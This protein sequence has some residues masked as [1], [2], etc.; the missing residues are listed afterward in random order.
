MWKKKRSF[1]ETRLMI[2]GIRKID[3]LHIM[4]GI[5]DRKLTL[6]LDSNA[7]DFS[8]LP[9]DLEELFLGKNGLFLGK[10]GIVNVRRLASAQA[11]PVNAFRLVRNSLR[12]FNDFLTA[13][14][15]RGLRCPR[16][17]DAPCTQDCAYYSRYILGI[18]RRYYHYR[19]F[20]K[21]R[22]SILFIWLPRICPSST[23]IARIC[24]L[25]L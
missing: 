9:K 18:V 11:T 6:S 16:Q 15:E 3:T 14:S 2:T 19:S 5:M 17:A 10:N 13:L 24:T 4:D 1:H 12:L 20:D 22:M 7:V 8:H 25:Q 21:S 23:L